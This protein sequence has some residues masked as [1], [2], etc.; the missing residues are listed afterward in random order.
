MSAAAPVQLACPHCHVLNRVPPDRLSDGAVCGRCRQALFSG[1]PI[2]LDTPAFEAHAMR[3][4]LPLLVDFWAAWCGPCR[5]MAPQFERA[6]AELEPA[7]RL[8]KLDTEAQPDIAGR[9]GIRSIPTL[10]LLQQGRERARR[11]GAMASAQIV[12]WVRG[13]LR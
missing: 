3:S 2:E 13:E 7:V 10:V 8:G 9:Y 6:A 11:S 5:A 1:R 12:D 4:E